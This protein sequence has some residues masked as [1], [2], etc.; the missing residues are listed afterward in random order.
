MSCYFLG[1]LS[2]D[3]ICRYLLLNPDD[4]K[5]D[6]Q[7]EY[8]SLRLQLDHRSVRSGTV[9]ETTFKLSIYD[10]SY[11]KHHEQQGTLKIIPEI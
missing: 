2:L 3:L 8:V 7:N 5:I 9:V 11:G 1:A 4:I 10:Q 6:D